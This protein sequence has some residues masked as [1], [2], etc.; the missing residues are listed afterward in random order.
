VLEPLAWISAACVTALT[1]L[2]VQ[3]GV[4]QLGVS[5]QL[6]WIRAAPLLLVLCSLLPH[7]AQ[8]LR[9]AASLLLAVCAWIGGQALLFPRRSAGCR[10]PVDTMLLFLGALLLVTAPLPSLSAVLL[11]SPAERASL[12]A[13]SPLLHALDA[14]LGTP[15]RVLFSGVVLATLVR[16]YLRARGGEGASGHSSDGGVSCSPVE[17]T[18]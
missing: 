8:P 7:P 3:L 4:H 17:W 13:T 5:P 9:L 12:C 1:V 16:P 18:D 6:R 15:M 14:R 10:Y 2:A 11:L